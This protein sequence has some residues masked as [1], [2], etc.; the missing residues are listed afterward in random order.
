MSMGR[1]NKLP[2]YAP[3][4]VDPSKETYFV[5]INCEPRGAN[6]LAKPEVAAFIWETVRY[7]RDR[8]LWNYH[9]ILLMPDHLHALLNFPPS[10]TPFRSLI[11][12]WKEWLAKQLGIRWQDDFFE[13]RLRSDE[14]LNQKVT[15]ILENPIR[16]GLVTKPEDWPFVLFNER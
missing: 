4:W 15:Y 12:K 5:T 16:K 14:S 11:S 7:R 8:G 13:H 9:V 1:G 6:Q 3:L 2:H 10:D